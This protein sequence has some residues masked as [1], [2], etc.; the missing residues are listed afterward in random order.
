MLFMPLGIVLGLLPATPRNLALTVSFFL[1]TIAIE[2]TQAL[3]PAL[4]R[5]CESADMVD[6]T[7]GL[8]IGLGF[9]VTLTH[10]RRR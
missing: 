2:L 8:I 10:L 6:N 5:G 1:L 3:V 9:G 4:G 7:V